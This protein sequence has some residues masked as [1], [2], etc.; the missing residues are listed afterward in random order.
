MIR[1]IQFSKTL[2]YSNETIDKPNVWES[3]LSA[4]TFGSYKSQS[5]E[6]FGALTQEEKAIYFYLKEKT[7]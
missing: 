1:K 5:L 2:D 6:D 3:I 4:I 7:Y